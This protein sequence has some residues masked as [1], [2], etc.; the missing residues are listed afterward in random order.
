[1]K[2]TTRRRF[3]GQS[4]ILGALAA[5]PPVATRGQERGSWFSIS[6]AEWSQHRALLAGELD[7]LDF[8]SGARTIFGIDA[9]EYVN[10]FFFDRARDTAYLREMQARCDGETL[11]GTVEE[12]LGDARSK[13]A[14]SDTGS[15]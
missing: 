13:H 6:L 3:L 15:T 1:M 12:G 7:H 11:F 9:V 10:V 8:I 2:P 14:P 5:L 4:A